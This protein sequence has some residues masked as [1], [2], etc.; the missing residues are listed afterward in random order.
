MS[1]LELSMDDWRATVRRSLDDLALRSLGTQ[2]ALTD[3]EAP[4]HPWAAWVPLMSVHDSLRLGLL[5]NPEGCQQLARTFVG[6]EAELT[7][8]E[9]GDALGEILNILAGCVKRDVA[10]RLPGL[11]IGL[12]IFLPHSTGGPVQA[13]NTR[14]AGGQSVETDVTWLRVSDVLTGLILVRYHHEGG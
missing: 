14:T 2:V 10:D 9:V 3:G 11:R 12:P 8:S 1:T 4:G 5:A 6:D 7:E 13:G